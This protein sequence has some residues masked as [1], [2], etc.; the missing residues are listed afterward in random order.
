MIYAILIEADQYNSLGGSCIRDLYNMA[1]ALIA[2]HISEIYVLYNREINIK[3]FPTCYREKL[4]SFQKQIQNIIQKLKECDILLF[5][6][7]GHGYQ[8]KDQDGDEEDGYDEYI[9]LSCGRVTDDE[10]HTLLF[11]NLPVNTR[12]IGICDTCH[13]GS[14][15]DLDYSYRLP[16]WEKTS[17]K[18]TSIEA[19]S[20]GACLDCQSAQCEVGNIIGFGGALSIH[21][22]ENL[23]LYKLFSPHPEDWIYVYEKLRSI[24]I[25]LNQMPS[26][27]ISKKLYE[28]IQ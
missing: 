24:M 5:Y 21:L 18:S 9:Q 22:I 16:R 26:L 11:T 14:M 15:F 27:Q 2:I 25:S 12:V 7:S 13:S 19:I 4:V 8:M 3:N 28:K 6:I 17:K 23:L 1:N 20:I 10:L